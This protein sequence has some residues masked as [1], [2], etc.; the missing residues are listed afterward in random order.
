MVMHDRTVDGRYYAQS[1][2]AYRYIFQHPE[3]LETPPTRVMEDVRQGI[4]LP[5][6]RKVRENFSSSKKS[7][8][9][10]FDRFFR[11]AF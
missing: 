6:G 9:D 2:Q 1:L 5:P 11:R 10:F 3:I 7:C 8:R 4:R